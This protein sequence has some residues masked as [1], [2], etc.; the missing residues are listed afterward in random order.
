MTPPISVLSATAKA[1]SLR[2]SSTARSVSPAPSSC[3]IRIEI[4]L[5]VA[6]KAQKKRLEIVEEMFSAEM[7]SNPRTE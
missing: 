7:T 5:P 1:I 2:S 6:K 4:A 3:P